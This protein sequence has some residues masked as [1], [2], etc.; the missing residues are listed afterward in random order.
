M[1]LFQGAYNLGQHQTIPLNTARTGV[2]NKQ[3]GYSNNDKQGSGA[4]AHDDL[5]KIEGEV[6]GPAAL[7]DERP[8]GAVGTRGA[9]HSQR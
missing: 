7:V 2:K 1:K 9:S 8:E 4:D 5:L 6:E 3:T